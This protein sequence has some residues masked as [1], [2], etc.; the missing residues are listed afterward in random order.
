M[1][2]HGFYKFSDTFQLTCDF[3]VAMLD[4]LIRSSLSGELELGNFLTIFVQKIGGRRIIQAPYFP[5][6]Y[7]FRILSGWWFLIFF[8]FTPIWG[9]FPV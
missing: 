8:I 4:F 1:N 6:V 7:Y 2:G 9:R 5:P 3:T